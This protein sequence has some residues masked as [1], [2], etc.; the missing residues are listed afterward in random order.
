MPRHVPTRLA[1][2]MTKAEKKMRNLFQTSYTIL[3]F[4]NLIAPSLASIDFH[5]ATNGDNA[6]D[7]S[8]NAPFATLDRARDAIRDLRSAQ[9][10]P[11]GPV[12]VWIHPGVYV[13]NETLKFTEQDSGTE[14]APVSYRS[15]GGESPIITGGAVLA[16]I[17]RGSCR[18]LLERLPKSIRSRVNLYQIESADVSTAAQLH[19]R[20][21]GQAMLPAPM[22]LFSG[23]SAL[24]RA[25]WPNSEWAHAKP[26]GSKPHTIEVDRKLDPRDVADCWT[27]GFWNQDWADSFDKANYDSI[28]S[29]KSEITIHLESSEKSI[30]DDARFRIENLLSE[31]DAPGEWYIDRA[32]GRVVVWPVSSEASRLVI[33][34]LETSISAYEAEYL[35]FDGLTIEG[36]TAMGIEIVGGRNVKLANCTIRYSGNVGVNIYHG[37][38]HSIARC[39]VHGT[40]SSGIRIEGGDRVTLE[41]AGHSCVESN[42]HDCCYSYCSQRPAVA[43]YGVGVQV[44]SNDIYNQPD[45]AIHL[46]GNEHL[47]ESNRIHHV[48]QVADD[49]GAISIAHDPT[50]RG[51][52]ILRNHIHDIGGF[53]QRDI[54]GIYLDNF[55]SGTSVQENLL[56]RTI[57]GIVIGGGRDN[58]LENN[59]ITDCLAGIQVD[60]RGLS[61]AKHLFHGETPAYHQYCSAVSH[62]HETYAQRYPTLANVLEDEPQLAKGNVIRSNTISCPITIDLQDGLTNQVVL[63]EMNRIERSSKLA[64]VNSSQTFA[65]DTQSQRND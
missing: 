49:V 41:P 22:E 16:P 3:L 51:N 54:V 18:D 62:N 13:L 28:G 5:V 15:I 26:I 27:H 24:P 31:L 38:E 2:S 61:W 35:T 60:C 50:F 1:F 63:L 33:S 57:R 14:D 40:G 23:A 59:V 11:L 52:Q 56:E 21:L 36:T 17:E 4:V 12:T 55:A 8:E 47:V 20:V 6:H 44:K 43:V 48:C 25:G 32:T 34:S 65:A 7:G 30:R 29:N 45:A 19:Q 58:V 53:G 46:H 9:S 10:E 39:E 64:K 42:I 37:H